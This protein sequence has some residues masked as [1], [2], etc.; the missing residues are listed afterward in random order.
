MSCRLI[1]QAVRSD[2][3]ENRSKCDKS[4]KLGIKLNYTIVNQKDR[5]TRDLDIIMADVLYFKMAALKK[6]IILYLGFYVK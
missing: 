1:V 5:D 2:F 4:V 3:Y 6:Q